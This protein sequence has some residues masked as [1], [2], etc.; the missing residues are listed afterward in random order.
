M[1][2]RVGT[3]SLDSFAYGAFTLYDGPSQAPSARDEICNSFRSN[4]VTQGAPY[5]PDTT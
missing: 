1:V 4:E 5:N 3:R 2:L